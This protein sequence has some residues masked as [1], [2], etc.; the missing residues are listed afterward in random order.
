MGHPGLEGR[1]LC[2]AGVPKDL[3]HEVVLEEGVGSEAFQAVAAALARQVLEQEGP[4]A[5]A[6]MG[7]IDYEGHLGNVTVGN[8]VVLRDPDQLPASLS[9]QDEMVGLS[10]AHQA[11]KLRI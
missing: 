8:A 6:L 3:H 4:Q 2:E 9:D 7:V 11:G 1:T 10:L 5:E